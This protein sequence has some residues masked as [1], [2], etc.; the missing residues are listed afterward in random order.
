MTGYEIH[1]GITTR[2]AALP[3]FRILEGMSSSED[4]GARSDDGLVWG[5]Y[6]HGV[7]DEPG[8]RR[9][10]INRV[11]ARKGL[12]ILDISISKEVST[13]LAGAFDRWA[14][15]IETH[16]DLTPMLSILGLR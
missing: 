6:I 16:V 11:R 15:H 8:F 9:T 4:D 3:C 10:W 12:P 2:L 14:D 7:F 1:M 5:T 13:R